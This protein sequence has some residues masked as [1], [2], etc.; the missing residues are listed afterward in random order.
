M[1]GKSMKKACWILG[2]LAVCLL[3]G[4]RVALHYWRTPR[5][6]DIDLT[7]QG[8]LV[9]VDGSPS[10][11]CTVQVRGE[12]RTWLNKDEWPRFGNTEEAAFRINGKALDKHFSCMFPP[13]LDGYAAATFRG[14]NGQRTQYIIHEDF[15]LM[16][17][18]LTRDGQRCLLVAPA[19]SREEAEAL[20]AEALNF[21][22]Q[23]EF[24]WL[25][26]YDFDFSQPLL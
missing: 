1:V 3:I 26:F 12:Y 4:G 9:Y 22:R 5:T 14:E 18:E 6:E 20:V 19:G 8:Y 10:E 7:C 16:M 21:I 25:E 24:T 2:V 13:D 15:H 23:R 11:V 17:I